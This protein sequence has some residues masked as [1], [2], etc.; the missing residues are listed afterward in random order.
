MSAEGSSKKRFLLKNSKF[1]SVFPVLATLSAFFGFFSIPTVASIADYSFRATANLALTELFFYLVLIFGFVKLATNQLKYDITN[2]FTLLL[3]ILFVLFSYTVNATTINLAFIQFCSLAFV[4][5]SKISFDFNE[6]IVDVSLKI[7]VGCNLFA[8]ALYFWDPNFLIF[9]VKVF[10]SFRGFSFDRVELS[11]ILSCYLCFAMLRKQ[12]FI[13]SCIIF[14]ILLTESRSG[15]LTAFLILIYYSS[16]RVKTLSVLFLI[17]AI[18]LLF[19]FSS[20]ADALLSVGQRVQ[21]AMLPFDNGSD[22]VKNILFGMGSLYSNFTGWVPHN[23]IIQTYL[24]FGVSGLLSY[25]LFLLLLITRISKQNAGLLIV[26]LI[27]GLSH[28]DLELFSFTV[29]NILWIVFFLSL[30]NKKPVSL[31][32]RTK[33]QKTK[34]AYG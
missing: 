28:Q 19:M 2:L 27:F 13:C 6:R 11:Y 20:R 14:L 18:P 17:V 31:I 12:I 23:N 33:K 7:F 1:L 21:L 3:A 9:P 5:F 10:G 8:A 4:G 29:E 30:K 26:Y 24:N 25:S 22:N 15:I 34:C 32:S 16:P